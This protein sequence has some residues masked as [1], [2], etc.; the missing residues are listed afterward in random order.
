MDNIKKEIVLELI[1]EV[2]HSDVICFLEARKNKNFL[3]KNQRYEEAGHSRDLE[4]LLCREYPLLHNLS[5]LLIS[6]NI[7]SF[8]REIK[9]IK[10]LDE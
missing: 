2:P 6:V 8:I 1:K 5:E 4:K 9:L 7:D 3:V 10:V